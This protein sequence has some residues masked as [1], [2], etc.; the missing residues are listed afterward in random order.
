RTLPPLSNHARRLQANFLLENA[1]SGSPSGLSK[2]VEAVVLALEK[3]GVVIT[4]HGV[5]FTGRLKRR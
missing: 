4:E 5:E 3:R 1:A 2:N